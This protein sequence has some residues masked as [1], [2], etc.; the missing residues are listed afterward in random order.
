MSSIMDRNPESSAAATATGLG[1][2]EISKG[3]LTTTSGSPNSRAYI[4]ELPTELFASIIRTYMND[5]GVVEAW[6]MRTV[7]RKS[8]ANHPSRQAN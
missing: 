4:L 5:V 8:R 6:H 2:L 3:D 1:K 7:C